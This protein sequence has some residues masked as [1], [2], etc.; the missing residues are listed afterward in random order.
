LQDAEVLAEVGDIVLWH[1]DYFEV[2]ATN[3]NR[4]FLG[5][6]NE[7]NYSDSVINFGASLHVV[8]TAHYARPEISE[9]IKNRL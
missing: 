8:C 2:E 3:E 9:I 6:D 5:K 4:L 1:D 7:Y